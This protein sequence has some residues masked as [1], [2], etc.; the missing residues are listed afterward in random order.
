MEEKLAARRQQ[1][2]GM[3]SELV[4]LRDYVGRRLKELNLEGFDQVNTE[5]ARLQ[6]EVRLIEELL[7]KKPS[8]GS[9]QPDTVD[10]STVL[11]NA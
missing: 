10:V 4:D 6:G 9:P 3:F 5:M 8:V 1:V 2:E 7:E 11:D